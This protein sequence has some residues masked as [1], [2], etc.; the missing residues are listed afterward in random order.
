MYQIQPNTSVIHTRKKLDEGAQFARS[1]SSWFSWRVLRTRNLLCLD[2][3]R[4]PQ[5]ARGTD[6]LQHHNHPLKMTP[7]SS[8][9]AAHAPGR[10]SSSLDAR[11]RSASLP[12]QTAHTTTLPVRRPMGTNVSPVLKTRSTAS[13]LVLPR[14]ANRACV[15]HPHTKPTALRTA[16][17]CQQYSTWWLK[18]VFFYIFPPFCI[19]ERSE[20]HSAYIPQSPPTLRLA[21]TVPK[22]IGDGGGR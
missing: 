12:R 14:P 13:V 22:V 20:T 4:I 1:L 21:K 10:R 19:P 15:V 16:N 6:V 18:P 3:L 11:T 8:P 9:S 7:P 5:A 17:V 2:V